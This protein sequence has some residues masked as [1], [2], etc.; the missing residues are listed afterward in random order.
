MFPST[1]I[2]T[3]LLLGD[4]EAVG[5]TLLAGGGSILWHVG[6]KGGKL[7]W[8]NYYFNWLL[9]ITYSQK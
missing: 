9:I 7:Q 8:F 5:Q 2:F 4:I 3:G 1:A 6:K